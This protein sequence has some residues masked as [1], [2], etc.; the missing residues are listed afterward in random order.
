M[1]PV[2][3]FLQPFWM[4]LLLPLWLYLLWWFRSQSAVVIDGLAGTGIAA[5]NH[6]YHPLARQLGEAAS[7]TIDEQKIIKPWG[8]FFWL[9]IIISLLIIALAHPV[10][11]GERLPDPPPERDIIFL[12]DTSVSMQ[13]KDYRLEGKPV[14]RMDLLR[15]LLNEFSVKMTGESISI[16]VFAETPYILVP[17]SHDQSLIQRQL[18]RIT[19]TLAGR[20]TAVGDALLLALKEAQ[21]QKHR[22][23]TFILFTDA[24]NSR[25]KVTP[26]AAATLVAES[27]IP[28]F[29]I[30][31]GSSQQNKGQA[32]KGGLYQGVN[33]ALLQNLA[34]ITG[35]KSYQA[36]DSDALK[37]ALENIL[38]QQQ[39][40]AEIIPVYRQESL[41]LY[42]LLASLGLFLLWQ[43]GR[44]ISQRKSRY[45]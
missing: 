33:L 22:Q 2:V 10:M 21:K 40:K 12:V 6:Y 23:Q 36:N 25:G 14:R 32:V 16:I 1:N 17:L 29:T 45:V 26:G 7:E 28:V 20:Y 37:N 42:P 31:I 15:N 18:A 13:L 4:W 3:Q 38:Q 35:G 8:T 34:K 30:A 5:N 44:L 9:G 11:M 19:T 43:L 27:K 24:D 39:N 41:Y